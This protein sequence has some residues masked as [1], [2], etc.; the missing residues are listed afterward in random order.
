MARRRPWWRWFAPLWIAFIVT[1]GLIQMLTSEPPENSGGT[2]FLVV[3]TALGLV[4]IT[5]AL[6][7]LLYRE[8][9]LVTTDALV[10]T[11]GIGPLRL[12]RAYR[13]DAIADLRVSP[14]AS[15]PW[16][17]SWSTY[18]IGGTV[19]FDYGDRTVRVAD[20]DEPEAKRVIAALADVG[21][22]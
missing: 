15:S 6:W 8:Q 16:R 13:R 4:M 1:F 19:A 5:F 9:L 22:N 7:A 10:H 21:V 11:R 12:R 14:S 18:G 17:T 20:V 2:W 3:W